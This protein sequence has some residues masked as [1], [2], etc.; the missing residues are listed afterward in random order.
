MAMT[1]P[2]PTRPKAPAVDK[3]TV[4]CVDDDPA[5]LSSLRRLFR[6]QPWEVKTSTSPAQA[7]STLRRHPVS[8]IISDE[9]MPD[10]SGA[11]F[12]A[13]VRSRWPWIG[14]VILTAYPGHEIMTRGMEAGIDFLLFKPWDGESLKRTVGRLIDE[15]DRTNG[16][17]MPGTDEA[18][19]WELGGE[20]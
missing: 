3:H 7:L 13:E 1:R 20:G 12:L 9:R 17:S 14:L 4:L 16:R 19:R 18:D 6:D 5:V 11:E 2:A 15:V 8:V 10:A